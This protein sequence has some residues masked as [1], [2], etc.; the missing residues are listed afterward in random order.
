VA[1]FREMLRKNLIRPLDLIMLSRERI[2]EA[3]G[4]AVS[5]GRMTADDASELAASLIQR[6]RK[7]TNDVL[8]D[9]EGL[10]GRSREEV[11]SRTEGARR[12]VGVGPSFPVT[13]YDDLTV[14][15]VKTRLTN[16]SS[17]ELR[18]VRDY[19]R[20]HANRKSVLSTIESKLT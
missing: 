5:R 13:G 15:Q 1:E 20:R 7:Q 11:E 18:K 8:S 3:L 4:D 2:E 12:R 16:L 14:E 9:L 19:E 10:L 17:P 6:G